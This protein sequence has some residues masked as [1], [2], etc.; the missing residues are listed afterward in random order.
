MERTE[1]LTRMQRMAEA[2][3]DQLAP[4]YWVDY[5]F[6]E[7]ATHL[8]Y[9]QKMLERL[10]PSGVILSAGCGAGRYDG[11]LLEAGYGVVGIDLSAG[12][13]ARARER[14]PQAYYEKMAMQAMDFHAAFDGVICLDALEHNSPEDYPLILGKFQQALKPGGWLYFTADQAEPEMLERA[15]R[16][17]LAQELP[18]VFGEVVEHVDADFAR[19]QALGPVSIPSD[20]SDS[21]IYHFYPSL[22]QLHRWIEQAGLFIE[23]EGTGSGYRH[24]VARN[25][26]G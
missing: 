2:L 6:Y 12:M 26:S 7:N 8:A 19:V 14:F 5:G 23:L 22:G 18:V 24:C 9:L 25:T 11:L 1:W 17:A 21:A 15:Y 13:L 4:Q 16:G 10:P 20:L 3:Y